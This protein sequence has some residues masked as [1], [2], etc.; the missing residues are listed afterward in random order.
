MLVVRDVHDRDG[1]DDGRG[2][3]CENER[4]LALRSRLH[5]H[6]ALVSSRRRRVVSENR[7]LPL[8]GMRVLVA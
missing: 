4:V 6:L 7:R 1:D 5:Q 8:V 3:D 2:R